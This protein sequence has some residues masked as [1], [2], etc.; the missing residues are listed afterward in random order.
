MYSILITWLIKGMA[1]IGSLQNERWDS[2]SPTPS[3]R[4]AS[5]VGTVGTV[6]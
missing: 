6:M 1:W 2:P 5:C 3:S 4:I